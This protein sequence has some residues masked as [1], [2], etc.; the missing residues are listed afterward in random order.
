MYTF[1]QVHTMHLTFGYIR[2]QNV[3][4]FPTSTGS[5]YTYTAPCTAQDPGHCGQASPRVLRSQE[6]MIGKKVQAFP[7]VVN[8][9]HLLLM[10]VAITW[11]LS[12]TRLSSP[13]T[14]PLALHRSLALFIRRRTFPPA[15]HT[16]ITGLLTYR[17]TPLPVMPF[18][19]QLPPRMLCRIKHES[20]LTPGLRRLLSWRLP[21]SIPLSPGLDRRTTPSCSNTDI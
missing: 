6:V 4:R 12:P 21:R 17:L 14:L 15:I 1:R 8:Q 13:F 5:Q 18:V 16:L 9:K 3:I 10:Q 20:P 11:V 2:K 7:R 19:A